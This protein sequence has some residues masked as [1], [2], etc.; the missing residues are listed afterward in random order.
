MSPASNLRYGVNR[1]LSGSTEIREGEGRSVLAAGL[2]FFV[3]LTVI[4]I[5]RPVREALGLSRGIENV[6][7]LFLVTLG[8]TLLIAPLFGWLVS[9]VPRRMLLS[10]SFRIC[11]LI[12]LGFLAGLTLFP[13]SV[14]GAVA[15]VYYVY[16]SAFNLFVVSL[17]WAFMADVY[18]LTESKRLFPAI[19]IGG[20][21]GALFGSLL[22][23]QLADRVGVGSLF[24]L[25]AVF[26]ELAVW[27]AGLVT[28]TRASFV[29]EPSGTRSIG[30]HSLAGITAVA[31]SFY[32]LG[33]AVFVAL[34]AVVSTF[35]YFGGLRLVEAASHTVEE[36]T[37]LF[38]SLNIWIQFITLLAQAMLTGRMMRVAGVGTAL[39]VLPGV[40]VCGFAVLVAA[41]S[42]I[43][44][45]IVSGLVRATQVGVTRPARETLF[46]VLAPE[47][48]YK[49]KSFIDTFCYR[50]GDAFGAQ[51]ELLLA[52]LGLGLLPVAVVLLPLATAWVLLSIFLGRTQSRLG[53]PSGELAEA[54][55]DSQS[56]CTIGMQQGHGPRSDRR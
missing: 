14:R 12:L 23:S 9:R 5:L 43:V 40:A 55:R 28:R 39:A 41:P 48:K 45:A 56:V 29:K 22:S 13:E 20:T 18:S 32:I 26:L 19:A 4:M 36:R 54:S 35:L 37:A 51:V 27:V 38:A 6:R 49:A 2:L 24:V 11:A 21:L 7:L 3:L 31:S 33:I 8:A 52:S 47:Q 15:S 16:H 25:A 50:A 46:T 30:G 10:V 1:V 17:F 42:L 34:A 44:Y 53:S